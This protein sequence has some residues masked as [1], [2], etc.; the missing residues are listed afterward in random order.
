[1]EDRL[2]DLEEVQTF[3]GMVA[4]QVNQAEVNQNG[5]PVEYLCCTISA[6]AQEFTCDLAGQTRW[7]NC[8]DHNTN[9][10]YGDDLAIPADCYPIHF[11][12]QA[13]DQNKRG[14]KYECRTVEGRRI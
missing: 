12:V 9:I 13:V 8:G 6:D 11:Y 14:M 1:M 7:L 4:S 10:F 2:G 3:P 5:L